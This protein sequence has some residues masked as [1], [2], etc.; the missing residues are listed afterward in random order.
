M[1]IENM[2]TYQQIV[3]K[4]WISLGKVCGYKLLSEFYTQKKITFYLWITRITLWIAFV[5]GRR[6]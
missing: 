2:R 5:I 1:S 6:M 4:L 3:H